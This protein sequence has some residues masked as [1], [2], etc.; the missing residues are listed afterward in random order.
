M[1]C[2]ARSL[3][4]LASISVLFSFPA[5]SQTITKKELLE[6]GVDTVRCPRYVADLES[7]TY[8]KLKRKK[9]VCFDSKTQAKKFFT[10]SNQDLFLGTEFQTASTFSLSGQGQ[11]NSPA[12]LIDDIPGFLSFDYTG[13]GKFEIELYDLEKDKKIKTV[14]KNK[15]PVSGG[16]YILTKGLSY[17]RIDADSGGQWTISYSGN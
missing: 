1:V 15:G 8:N 13:D 14:S 6:Q 17:I 12:I 10:K 4:F 7:E 9:L 2:Y 16:T 5:F 3:G 11:A